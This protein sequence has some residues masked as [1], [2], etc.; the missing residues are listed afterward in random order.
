MSIYLS[1]DFKI[2]FFRTPSFTHF[3]HSLTNFISI[4]G[5]TVTNILKQINIIPAVYSVQLLCLLMLMPREKENIPH[6][7]KLLSNKA[8]T[9][10]NFLLI[11]Y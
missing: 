7:N 10:K 4:E 11:T 1:L 6:V 5:C 8:V 3:F 9:I 2:L